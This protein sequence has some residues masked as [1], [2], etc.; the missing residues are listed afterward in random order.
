VGGKLLSVPERALR[1]RNAERELLTSAVRTT[2]EGSGRVILI[3]GMAGIGKSVLLDEVARAGLSA[4]CHVAAGQ[5]DELD[6][7]TPLSALLKGLR[8]GPRPVLT[9]DDLRGA[10]TS[11]QRMW[12]LDRLCAVLEAEAARRALVITIDDMQWADH[13]TLLAISSLPPRL[14]MVPI[15]WVLARRP[16]P[17][18]DPLEVAWR[19]LAEGGAALVHLG[20]V[21]R[22]AVAAMTADLV[23][24]PPSP[25]LARELGRAG[26]NPFYVVQLLRLL[27]E[28]GSVDVRSGTAQLR[29]AERLGE[30]AGVTP[31]LESLS[32]GARRLVRIGA[33]LGQ[34]FPLDVAAEMLGQPPGTLV[35]AVAECRSAQVLEDAGD[36]LV[37][38]HDLFREAAYADLPQPVRVALHR[39]AARL[40]PLHGASTLDVAP[41]LARGARVGDIAAVDGI[42]AASSEL[43]GT[44]PSAAADLAVRA[45]ELIPRHDGRRA[46]IAAVA[47]GAL[48]WAGRV[49]E[50]EAVGRQILL[51]G[52]LDPILEA[53]IELGMRAAWRQSAAGPYERPVPRHLLADERVPAPLRI[54]L[55]TLGELSTYVDD[56]HGSARRLDALRREADQCG[57]EP[58]IGSIWQAQL[59]AAAFQGRLAAVLA[60][61]HDAVAWAAD[62]DEHIRG[63]QG[64]EF[65]VAFVLY[66]LDRLD[67]AMGA[68]QVAERTSRRLGS[69]HLVCQTDAM[70]GAALLTAG[71]L[72]DA[73][74]AAESARQL[75]EDFGFA[76]LLALSTTVLG[77]VAL[78]RGDM[79]AAA[80]HA[81]RVEPL[82]QER[83]ATP[84]N[85]WLPAIVAGAGGEHLRA[86]NLLEPAIERLAANDFR[87]VVPNVDR[88]P[89]LVSMCQRA[90][91]ADLAACMAKRAVALA[92]LNPM[93]PVLDGVAAYCRGLVE[94][95]GE[96]LAVAVQHLRG[97]HRPLALA[98]AL[99]DL[100]ESCL[101]AGD[102]GPA[103]TALSEAY[104][105]SSACGAQRAA[106]RLRRRLRAV[107]VVKRSTA[108]AR[109]DAGWESL[110]DAEIAVVDLVAA[111]ESSRSV[112]ERLFLSINT[113]NTHL[114][115]VFTKLG[116]RSRV[117][118]ARV[119]FEHSPRAA[120][121][122]RIT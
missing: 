13:A 42:R 84:D 40:L 43:M 24:C 67:E 105:L 64:F 65:T 85:A 82:V 6:Q 51:E 93:T 50:A 114:R 32:D 37:F 110:T 86:L 49:A 44:N 70:R 27:M 21:D 46:D 95:D 78:A 10:E 79:A 15:L 3:D 8:A 101:V 115:H 71:R 87:L 39:D 19:R 54:G 69:T 31:H 107:G 94:R 99:E 77:E 9:S 91:R 4:N 60:G 16:S 35:D 72:D 7:I 66:T 106:A 118:L 102:A 36:A 1:G 122:S 12:V 30:V 89:Q 20:P 111:G 22:E 5:A 80:A 25:E 117:E 33:V 120:I 83:S 38:R 52:R 75:A 74:A 11:D 57:A 81:E 48:G 119:V 17:S 41:H 34:R 103:A 76:R 63:N 61:A 62:G 18:S 14:F 92:A 97:C 68:F 100:G 98:A 58:A 47:V 113:V 121:D 109:P 28:S 104:D 2:E 26:G 56:L 53:T 108:V 73:A 88:F 112:A 45:L 90:G 96:G 23:G 116:V 29:R 59:F 55:L